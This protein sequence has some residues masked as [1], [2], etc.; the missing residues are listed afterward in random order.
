MY[1]PAYSEVNYKTLT[2]IFLRKPKLK[3]IWYPMNLDMSN[4]IRSFHF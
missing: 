4:I 1:A 2:A 3:E